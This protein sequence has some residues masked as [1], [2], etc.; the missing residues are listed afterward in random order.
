M[1]G[2]V[3]NEL[4][5]IRD[6]EAA[7][8]TSNIEQLKRIPAMDGPTFTF[9]HFFPP[10]PPYLFDRDGNLHSEDLFDDTDRVLYIE[11]LIWVNRSISGAIDR[12][13]E[14]AKDRSVIVVLSDHGSASLGNTSDPYRFKERS[15]NLIAIHLPEICDRSGLYPTLTPVNILRLVFDGCLGTEFGLLEDRSFWTSPKETDFTPLQDML[16]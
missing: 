3:A 8:F 15:S 16:K 1:L 9:A 10:H 4:G 7:L 6:N 14:Q 5:W 11:Q 2:P 12:I 13:L